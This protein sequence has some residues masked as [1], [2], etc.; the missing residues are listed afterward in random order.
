MFIKWN[1]HLV[2]QE[3]VNRTINGIP[4]LHMQAFVRDIKINA[5]F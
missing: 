4:F 5:L 3:K 2:R 1:K